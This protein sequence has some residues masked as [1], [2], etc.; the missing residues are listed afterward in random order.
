MSIYVFGDSHSAYC[1]ECLDGALIHWLGP[2]TMHRIARDGVAFISKLVKRFQDD[3][4]VLFTVGEID[5]RC[6]LLPISVDKQTSVEDIAQDLAKRF[7]EKLVSF[8][9]TN[10]SVKI[11]VVQPP[12][13][14]D[15]R[16]NPD[17]P[18]TGTIEERVHIHNVLGDHLEKLCDRSGLFF[19]KMPSRYMDRNGVLRRKYSDDGVHIIPCEAEVLVKNLSRLISQDLHFNRRP[20]TI[21]R[22]RWSYFWG[23]S[24]RRKGLPLSVP[25]DIRHTMTDS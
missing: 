17:L 24:L 14:A 25:I 7:I 18:F 3:D 1:F 23:A 16:P 20:M 21:L 2:I 12:F 15:R 4:V 11:V 8:R 22:R 9:L 13:P 10:P 6:H 5:I 19:L